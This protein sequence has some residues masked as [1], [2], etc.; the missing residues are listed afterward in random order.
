MLGVGLGPF[1][2]LLFIN[3]GGVGG[4]V[5]PRR[6]AVSLLGS[7][8]SGGLWTVTQAWMPW[9][10]TPDQIHNSFIICNASKDASPLRKLLQVNM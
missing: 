8:S 2:R 5:E 6:R 4:F 1:L 10:V 3:R 7:P 9:S